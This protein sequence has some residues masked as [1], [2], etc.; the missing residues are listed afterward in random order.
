MSRLA[1]WTSILVIA[2]VGMGCGGQSKDGD[3]NN[4]EP[5]CGNGVLD[6]GESCDSTDFGGHTCISQGFLGG[7]LTR[8]PDLCTI[9][10]TGPVD[11]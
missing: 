5:L 2:A 7:T 3:N 1:R 11:A 9:D 6:P 4:N 8:T 10:T